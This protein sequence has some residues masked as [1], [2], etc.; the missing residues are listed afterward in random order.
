MKF[1]LTIIILLCNQF[2]FA[3]SSRSELAH[4]KIYFRAT[5]FENKND[6]IGLQTRTDLTDT[7]INHVIYHKFQT[8]DFTDYDGNKVFSSY[9]ESFA[10]SIYTLLD[11]RKNTIHK[12][13]YIVNKE[14]TGIIFGK[15]STILLEF[16][17]TK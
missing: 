15:Q 5:Y 14:Q 3:Q 8:A 16:I 1:P 7:T 9:Y 10:D 12:I 6:I 2:T 4:S 13:N 17:D 11:Y